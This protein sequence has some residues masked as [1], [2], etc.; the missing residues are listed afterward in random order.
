LR[1]SGNVRN[2][3]TALYAKDGQIRHIMLTLSQLRDRDNTSLGTIGISKDITREKKLL[4]ELVQSQRFAAIGQAVTGIQHAVKNML[5]ALKGGAYLVR[6]GMTKDDGP[7][8]REGWSMVEEGIDRISD[9]SR[10]LLQY[11]KEW[12]LDLEQTDLNRLL[13]QI[14]ER[15]RQSAAD[16]GVAVR[17]E[18]NDDLP[19]VRCDPK[20]IDMAA[21]DIV[22][23]AIDACTWKDY[24]GDETPEVVLRGFVAE[25]G[26]RAVI[27]VRD[28]GCGMTEEIRRNIFTPF[29]ST[30]KTLGT[31]LG[32]ALTARIIN[33]HGG[34]VSVES[35]PERGAT[36]R[37]HLPIDGPSDSGESVDGEAGVDR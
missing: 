35:A 20:L 19:A 14:G 31:G 17:Y 18:A 36:F 30:K 16:Q 2:Y 15:N 8:V 29:F 10:N 22:V 6:V 24:Q 11:A 26:R 5:N 12:K 34:D 1:D 37:I 33:V 4:R 21:T 3:E 32:L 7:R 27:E 28:N 9:L 23:N 25:D 13:A